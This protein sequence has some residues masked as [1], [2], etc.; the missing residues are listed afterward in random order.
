MSLS[1]RDLLKG[2]LASSALALW[3]KNAVTAMLAPLGAGPRKLVLVDLKGGNDGL[4]TVVPHGLA[5]GSY[6]TEFRPT[7]G[8]NSA[9]ALP[10]AAGIGL[11][12]NMTGLKTHFDAGRLAIVQGVHYPEPSFSHEFSERVWQTGDPSA[13][14]TAGWLG[15]HL[16]TQPP[17]TT[18]DTVSV[19]G[20]SSLL[21]TGSGGFTPAFKQL[22]SF[23]F[24]VDSWHQSDGGNR[25]A[26][27]TAIASSLTGG[28]GD[29]AAMAD[30]SLGLLDLID[31]FATVPE[32]NHVGLYPDTYVAKSF[33]LVARLLA[34]DVGMRSFYIPMGG[35]DTHADQN[36]DDDHGQRLGRVSALIDALYTD[37]ASFGLA[38][39]TLFI[40]F[41]EFG[42]TVY[43]N[44][45]GGT[46]HGTVNP[47]LLLGDA[48]QGGLVNEHPSME[49]AD[50]DEHG[51]LPA[52]VD[53]RDVFG[54]VIND[55]LGGDAAAVFPGHALT[56]LP[57]LS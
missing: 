54:G 21:V 25:R 57:L 44:G 5:G 30:T 49:P 18:P 14:S 13:L 53:L 50:L 10:L 38:Q 29:L 11:H 24:P 40:V 32:F 20:T 37:L 7:I 42:R 43:E 39:D 34:A 55:W 52:Q 47:V 27:F 48:V 16:A 31:L 1:R 51:E 56:P 36:L 26:A 2:V 35:F 41:S 9:A 23:T 33:Q 4:N 19:S 15:R 6:L 46:D 45:S 28:G 3:P 8:V 17:P 12:P 22:E